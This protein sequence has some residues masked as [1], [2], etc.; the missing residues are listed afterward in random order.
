MVVG[1]PGCLNHWF[2]AAGLTFILQMQFLA[3]GTLGLETHLQFLSV[4]V[5]HTVTAWGIECTLFTRIY[6]K[7]LLAS[8][9]ELCFSCS[10]LCTK[11]GSG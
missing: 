6:L 5:L 11:C 9:C 3:L 1:I 2:T 10:N 4:T 8:S 7:F